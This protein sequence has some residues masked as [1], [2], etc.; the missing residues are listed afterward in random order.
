MSESLLPGHPEQ[1]ASAKSLKR[2]QQT[3]QAPSGSTARQ[4]AR[5]EQVVTLLMA[6][7]SGGGDSKRRGGANLGGGEG[8]L[9][10]AGMFRSNDGGAVSDGDGAIPAGGAGD[11]KGRRL[12]A[13]TLDLVGVE[14]FRNWGE[15][16]EETGATDQR[17]A[18]LCP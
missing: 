17:E 13:C 2:R 5:R 6:T 3:N 7:G 12:H 18:A 8:N 4:E 10:W 9:G 15:I 11:F 16:D 1:I 14:G